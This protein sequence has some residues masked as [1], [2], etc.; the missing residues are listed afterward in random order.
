MAKNLQTA[1]IRIV[2]I[3]KFEQFIVKF[4]QFIV[5]FEQFIVKYE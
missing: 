1:K 5:K 2:F 3:V 4:E